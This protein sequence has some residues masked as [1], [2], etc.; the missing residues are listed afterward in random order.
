MGRYLVALVMLVPLVLMSTTASAGEEPRS[1]LGSAPTK[2]HGTEGSDILLYRGQSTERVWID[3]LGEFVNLTG[4][5]EVVAREEPAHGAGREFGT[6]SGCTVTKWSSGNPTKIRQSVAPYRSYVVNSGY[7]RLS[8]GCSYAQTATLTLK[9]P[10]GWN[11]FIAYTRDSASKRANPGSGN[12]NVSVSYL[13][14][15]SS[16]PFYTYGSVR[17]GTSPTVY[18]CP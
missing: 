18:L 10:S 7:L 2:Q 12:A 1:E 11:P 3:G 8:S 6:M 5:L 14:P 13:C 16:K 17:Q 15:S 9:E 4:T